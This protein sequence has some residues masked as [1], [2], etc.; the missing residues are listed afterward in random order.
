MLCPPDSL[1]ARCSEHYLGHQGGCSFL[2][3]FH[4]NGKTFSPLD[5]ICLYCFIEVGF[6]HAPWQGQTAYHLKHQKI[7]YGLLHIDNALLHQTFGHIDLD[8]LVGILTYLRVAIQQT[9]QANS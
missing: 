6:S 9:E 7:C 8:Q 2:F 3:I 1:K 5:V 4:C